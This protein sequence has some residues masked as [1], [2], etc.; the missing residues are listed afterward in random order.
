LFQAIVSLCDTKN[1]DSENE[2]KELRYHKVI[3]L[4]TIP[5]KVIIKKNKKIKKDRCINQK[6]SKHEVITYRFLIKG[7][8]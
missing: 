8:V 2:D 1:E 3:K 6:K 5:Y 7:V 4:K